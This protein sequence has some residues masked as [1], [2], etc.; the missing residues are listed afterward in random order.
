MKS[1]LNPIWLGA[2]AMALYS[3]QAIAFQQTITV[4][5]FNGGDGT[6]TVETRNG[7]TVY[8]ANNYLYYKTTGFPTTATHA[9]L[10][11]TYY[12]QTRGPRLSLQYDGTSAAY[13]GS[14][15][16]IRSSG[17]GINAF[18]TSYH[19]LDAPLFSKRQNGGS[20]FRISTGKMPIQS[21]VVQDTPFPDANAQYALS[22]N[23]VWKQPYTGVV[24]NDVNSRTIKGKILA[25]YQ[26]WFRT[27]NDLYDG[28]FTHWTGNTANGTVVDQWPDPADYPASSLKAV[29]GQTTISNKP[30]YVFSSADKAV[31]SKHF[32]WMRK[33]NIDGVYLQ[34]F[35]GA[36][37]AGAT[38]EWVL[39]NVREAAA[40]EGRVWAIEY[41]LSG[42]TSATVYNKITTDWKW[43]V[44]TLKITQD[45]R[46]LRE[47]NKPVVV[48]WGAG[49]RQDMDATSLNQLVDFFKNDPVYGN[50]YVVGCVNQSFPAA[51]D[52]HYP[53][54]HSIFAWQGSLQN[55]AT[56]AA[57]YGINAQIHT[58]PGFS[59]HNLKGL[60]YPAS[61]TDRQN[62]Q[63]F[64]TRTTDGLSIVNPE[65][66]FV[67]MF[68]EYDES[69]AIM[70]MSD[71]PPKLIHPTIGH[72]LTN[73]TSSKDWWLVL[74]GQLQETLNK[75]IAFNTAMP[76]VS[77]LTNRSNIGEEL[78]VSLGA[79]NVSDRL[80]QVDQSG[81]GKTQAGAIFGI[82]CRKALD[83]YMYFKVD[84]SVLFN[85]SAGADVTIIVDYFDTG[86]G[87][88]I[89]LQYDGVNGAYTVHPK[90]FI[91][92]GSNTWRSARFEIS[93]AYFGNRQN[94]ASDFRLCSLSASKNMNI[95]RVRVILPE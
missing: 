94:G 56:R 52:T 10:K 71:D 69:T 48:L 66:I 60:V 63:Y 8:V 22:L 46:Y 77:S 72:Y 4:P 74:A 84:D 82:P 75:Q 25:G 19:R 45:D 26:G 70:P 80:Q 27:P 32:K 40:E 57:Q 65:A 34:R 79:T 12:D 59:W 9:Y 95:S 21:I 16:S 1:Q 3:G 24:N 5:S 39:R 41:D 51:W 2:I 93:N 55:V 91:V 20:D 58:W 87:V 62:G 31:V 83:Y 64:W 50:N 78:G 18:A 13:T 15:A 11:I 43:L 89:R 37:N 85:Q 14:S 36:S 42:G 88:D 73:G 67:G 7:Q 86:G 68:D 23:P 54:Y 33:Y 30:A 28:G 17:E 81:D 92:T 29:P 53:N 90:S 38:P 44:N 76:S 49:I 61:Y 47:G 35:F 6:Y